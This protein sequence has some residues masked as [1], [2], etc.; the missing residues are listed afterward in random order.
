MR[1]VGCIRGSV[2]IF[3]CC[4]ANLNPAGL[5]GVVEDVLPDTLRGHLRISRLF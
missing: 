3:V 1:V 4:N 5:S 2:D